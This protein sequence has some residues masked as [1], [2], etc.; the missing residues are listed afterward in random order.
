LE[1]DII[2][3]DT[4]VLSRLTERTDGL[5]ENACMASEVLKEGHEAVSYIQTC[6]RI[7]PVVKK[8]A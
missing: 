3:S 6:D 5:T 7:A 2:S 1:K 8:E 4:G